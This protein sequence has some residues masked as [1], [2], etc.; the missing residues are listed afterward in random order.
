M[1]KLC[2]IKQNNT[3]EWKSLVLLSKTKLFRETLENLQKTQKTKKTN[4]SDTFEAAFLHHPVS[5]SII[6]FFCFLDFCWFFGFFWIL[7]MLWMLWRKKLE[8]A[9]MRRFPVKNV[10]FVKNLAWKMTF[11]IKH[12]GIQKGHLLR[13]GLDD[14]AR[15]PFVSVSV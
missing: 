11:A 14:G 15:S 7:W 5:V 1:E 8:I 6:C 4:N 12:E 3:F 10:S 2:F 13:G 9:R